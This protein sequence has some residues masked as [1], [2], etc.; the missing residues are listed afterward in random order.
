[1]GKRRF[2]AWLMMVALM[3]TT[4]A[5]GFAQ[6]ADATA[7]IE[8]VQETALPDL[9]ET[10][11]EAA[12]QPE[13]TQDAPAVPQGVT[14]QV[15]WRL[16]EDGVLTLS[17]AGETADYMAEGQRQAAPWD[18]FAGKIRRI[19][20]EYGVTAVG[21]GAFAGEYPQLTEI[22]LPDGLER[23]G[24]KA[25]AGCA[26]V[27][28]IA[29]PGTLKEIGPEA[30]AGCGLK[31][32]SFAGT[33]EEFAALRIG[34][35]N[36]PLTD[37]LQAPAGVQ[38]AVEPEEPT[39]A[40]EAEEIPQE[41]TIEVEPQAAQEMPAEQARPARLAA[42][43]LRG[44]TSLSGA[45]YALE[46]AFNPEVREYTAVI[47]DD[48]NPVNQIALWATLDQGIEGSIIVSYV[49]LINGKAMEREITSGAEVG[50]TL[51]GCVK[52]RDLQENLLT[53]RIDGEAAYTIRLVKQPTLT[54]ATLTADGETLT[55]DRPLDGKNHTAS[56]VAPGDGAVTVQAQ[57]NA[58]GVEVKL[59]GEST[60]TVTPV[61]TDH[62]F[63]LTLTLSA[64]GAAEGSYRIFLRQAPAALEIVREPLK[65]E[66]EVGETFEI[67]GLELRAVYADGSAET[68]SAE[69]ITFEPTQ[70]LT[71]EITAITLRYR[72]AAVELPIRV[73]GGLRGSGTAADPWKIET[74]R[75][76]E[77]VRS[78][79]EKGMSFAGEYLEMT[80]DIT[81][82]QGWT[83]IGGS[84]S[85]P[86]SGDWNGGNF[87]LT[88]PE[89]GLPLLGCVNGAKV[90]NL[91]IYGARIA[92]YG[93]VNDLQGV[94]CSGQA[95]VIDHVTLK[96]GSATKKAGLIGTAPSSNPY[97]GC[98]R[99][100]L[101]TITNCTV[102][103]GVVIGY[104]KDQSAI[105]SLAGR[106]NGVIS[107]CTSAATVYGTDYVGG[108]LGTRDNAL[109]T[110]RVQDCAFTGSVVASGERAGGVVGGGYSD[111]SAP[112]GIRV[113]IDDCRVSGSV[114]GK[115]QV[116]GILGGDVFVAQAWDAYTFTGNSFTGILRADGDAVGGIIG[117][118]H[119]LN[120]WDGI[121]G[122]YY[123][124]GCGAQRGIGRVLYVDTN[125]A[126][127][128][129]QSG[130]IYFNTENGVQDCPPV[131]GCAWKK[132]HNRTDDPLGADADKLAYTDGAAIVP[133]TGVELDKAELNL[134][135]GETAELQATVLPENATDKT[136]RW[137]SSDES[138]AAVSQGKVTARAFG[139]TTISVQAGQCRAEC[140][141]TVTAEPAEA[142][143][144][145]L[146]VSN[147]GLLAQAADGS[148]MFYR[149]VTV[150]DRNSDGV[151]TYD[152]AL[153]AAHEAYCPG[154]YVS[155]ETAWGISVSRL[156]NVET[157]NCQFF[158]NDAALTGDVG[159]PETSALRAGD[160]LV[161]SVNRD[162]VYY[163]DQYVTYAKRA[164]TA[165]AGREF[166]VQLTGATGW[167]AVQIGIWENGAFSALEGAAVDDS[168]RVTLV[169]QQ[170]GEYLLTAWGEVTAT[171]QDWNAG[172]AEVT[173][174]CPIIAPG[175][176]VKVEKSG[177]SAEA[178]ATKL[179]I[180]G[181]YKKKYAQGE[182]MDFHGMVLKVAYS[183]GS[184][185]EIAPDD[186]AF[187]GF[188]T[189]QRGEKTVTVT[190]EGVSATFVITV[191]KASGTI[192]VT[193][194][195]LGDAKHGAGKV[196]TLAGGG[197]ATW[198]K[199]GTYN[200][201]AGATVW[202]LLKLCLDEHGMSCVNASGNYVSSIN[203]LSEFDNGKNSGWMYTLNGKYPLLGVSE[204]KL[205]EGD[206]VVFHYTDDY[207]LE[208]TG[209][210]PGDNPE[211][212][213]KSMMVEAVEKLI[214]NIGEVTFDEACRAKIQ[215][216]RKSYDQ[217]TYAEKKQVSNYPRLQAAEKQFAELEKAQNQARAD[218]VIRLIEEM[219]QDKDK[220]DAARKAYDQLT[221]E[222][223]KLVHNY[224]KL[225][226]AEYTR[227][228][229][230]ATGSD[231]NAA[232][233]ASA[234]IAAIG[235]KITRESA[236]A[237]QA[238]R[239]AYDALTDTQKA[240]VTN[241][242]LLEA[243]E[244]ALIR[245][246]ELA[247]YENLYAETGELLL[248]LGTPG[249][250]SI[251]GEWRVIGLARSG[252]PVDEGYFAAAMDYVA[253]N[254]DQR[255]RLNPNKCT[256][257]ARMILAL[258]ALGRNATDVEGYDLTAGL[259]EMAY[260]ENQGVNGPIWALIALDSGNYEPNPAGDVTREALTAS[261]LNAQLAD[262]G[263]AMAG[264]TA[265]ADMTAMALQALAPYYDPA[266]EGELN[267]AVEKGIECLSLLQFPDGGFGTY[268]AEGT[269]TATSESISQVIV[270]LTALGV[271]PDQDPRFVKNGVSALDALVQYGQ[272]NGGLAHLK[273]GQRDDMATEQGYYAMAAYAR[274]LMQA[275]RLYDMTDALDETA[276]PLPA[277]TVYIGVGNSGI[278][279]EE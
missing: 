141:V 150:Q 174:Q 194:S 226:Q 3:L 93:L 28:N 35:G 52:V 211:E 136:L 168:G 78:M 103:S 235:E 261:I 153:I 56:A 176:R 215:A 138:V 203:G 227:A 230:V 133:V 207:T 81:L 62:A 99:D 84:M 181:D 257:N 244:D 82:P 182:R 154:G 171:V 42:L 251:G 127:H 125:C 47:P 279:P 167:D 113:S 205:K 217:L 92:G 12:P 31:Q 54:G 164:S 51:M 201:K 172:G 132:A 58:S 70:P 90:S 187:T 32:V 239:S 224:G 185:R 190:F 245:L 209:F 23:I 199:A 237:V 91:K 214:D 43:S 262:G 271:D 256:D 129:T 100:F 45:E 29:L 25:F 27:E 278:E 223:K 134:K 175:C 34:E 270:A 269:V 232:D 33:A 9:E 66:Y 94:G 124:S 26:G 123:A 98:S 149:D 238:A 80:G 186:A 156:W 120:K 165:V 188:D 179:T 265:D 119:S 104:D 225:T 96:S 148:A 16:G 76:L 139:Q 254:A 162:Q 221:P 65:T 236:D 69:E 109:G 110:C 41:V 8:T 189:T 86:F 222:Q 61:W 122:N 6:E 275:P 248:R 114:S 75:D 213:G 170:P 258:T 130:A 192:D 266:G 10:I 4:A 121:S 229:A 195:L 263:W 206:R 63:E 118:Y 268:G 137:A 210:E 233:D 140:A 95:I 5:G 173:A 126:T 241:Y 131:T 73:G 204:Q 208:S 128:E 193:F 260:I 143:R 102:E 13:Q 259:D 89:G 53:L 106:I 243:A 46:P 17:G 79:V 242:P 77:T 18:A 36:Q 218:E 277:H 276:Q 22:V 184:T 116:G 198:I 220:I 249:V 39:P 2:L 234:R 142:I 178:K 44:S 180:S 14:G 264:E 152:E 252:C 108:I 160:V 145:N 247:D 212:P 7:A 163:A 101:V 38:A 147:R 59:N 1:M 155:S 177:T 97:A 57:T 166:T 228:S 83:P 64:P 151:L 19:S 20:V 246:E 74:Q 60:D 115:D 146:T 112:N 68:P 15:N 197:L 87:T 24:E 88:V 272:E 219:G 158:R 161:A 144:V 105:G 135:I 273:D 49:S 72:G 159:N 30:F 37:A 21:A 55:L 71:R 216:A 191:G 48:V 267:A 85:A 253:A 274:Y 240:L 196:H 117:Y 67:A 250:G 183:D 231:W 11:P 111:S 202:E 200:V 169:F 50:A 107:G 157:G 40:P 255:Q